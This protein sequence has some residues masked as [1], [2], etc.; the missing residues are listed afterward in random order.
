[1]G[2]IATAVRRI[3]QPLVAPSSPA[4]PA[5]VL[6]PP[7]PPAVLLCRLL[8]R[9]RRLT[10]LALPHVRRRRRRPG[11]LAPLRLGARRREVAREERRQGGEVG[12]V[13]RAVEPVLGLGDGGGRELVVAP[14]GGGGGRGRVVVEGPVRRAAAA[15]RRR[16]RRAARARGRDDEV[17]LEAAV[18]LDGRRVTVRGSGRVPAVV[19]VV[20]EVRAALDEVVAAAARRRA[21]LGEVDVER[22]RL[23]R[24]VLRRME[25]LLTQPLLLLLVLP[26]RVGALDRLGGRLVGVRPA[27]EVVEGGTG[28]DEE[29][30]ENVLQSEG[31]GRVSVELETRRSRVEEEDAR[32]GR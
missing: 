31:G 12:V 13:V 4:R 3:P 10:L 21:D 23:D 15:R 26:G 6:S 2:R 1:M 8:L 9:P 30:D 27:V 7:R 19:E 14:R 32:R 17:L 22:A 11:N 24:G 28:V 18:V 29:R 20:G 25:P 5:L 16:R